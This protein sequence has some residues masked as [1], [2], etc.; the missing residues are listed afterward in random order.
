MLGT[1]PWCMWKVPNIQHYQQAHSVLIECTVTYKNIWTL[2]TSNVE[3]RLQVLMAQ[4]HTNK[5]RKVIVKKQVHWLQTKSCEN[6]SPSSFTKMSLISVVSQEL[7]QKLF[8]KSDKILKHSWKRVLTLELKLNSSVCGSLFP[9]SFEKNMEKLDNK[10]NWNKLNDYRETLTEQTEYIIYI[11]VMK[12][13]IDVLTFYE[14]RWV[15]SPA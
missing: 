9:D 4:T 13:Y 10:W 5:V 6:C 3:S 7:S 11:S 8:G 1:L 15:Y 2:Q 14:K 12:L